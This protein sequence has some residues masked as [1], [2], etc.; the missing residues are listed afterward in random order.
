MLR[1]E[2]PVYGKVKEQYWTR[3]WNSISVNRQKENEKV[4]PTIRLEVN[5]GS[6]VPK[7]VLRDLE[8]F[9]EQFGT[10]GIRHF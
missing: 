7:S 8:Q 4:G 1:E 9:L 2:V 5:Y 10:L 6:G 3:T